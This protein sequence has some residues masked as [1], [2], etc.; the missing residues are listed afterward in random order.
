[1]EKFRTTLEKV[2]T[3]Q[4]KLMNLLKNSNVPEMKE[5]EKKYQET[6][7][8]MKNAIEKAGIGVND[9]GEEGQSERNTYI[10]W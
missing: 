1:M 3:A 10:P 6:S 8:L 7:E 2:E 4:T 5:F 9:L